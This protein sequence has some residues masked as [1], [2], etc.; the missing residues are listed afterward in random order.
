[1]Y[2]EIIRLLH[3]EKLY[4]AGPECFYTNGYTLWDSMKKK[5]E[6]Y[7]F[8]VTMP[9]DNPVDLTHEDLRE[10]AKAIFENCARCMNESTA[11]LVDLEAFR[12]AEPDG[13][14][15]FELGMAYARGIRCYGYTRDK[16]ATVW[17]HQ[18]VSLRDGVVCGIDGKQLPYQDIPFAP[19]IFGSS[20]IIEGSLD[21]CLGLLMIDIEQENKV[22]RSTPKSAETEIPEKHDR[23]VVYLASTVRYD[24]DAGKKLQEMKQLCQEY[25]YDVLTPLD[26]AAGEEMGENPYQLAAQ[27]FYRFQKHVRSCDIILADLNDFRG[28]EPSC[29]V[30]F[31][32]GM[33]YQLGKKLFGYMRDTS[34]MRERIPNYGRDREYRDECGRNAEDFDY[35]INLMFAGS[36]PI[37][38]ADC[39]KQAVDEMHRVLKSQAK[40]GIAL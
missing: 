35:P 2:D 31:E 15:I 1:M 11:I 19:S 22:M 37:I 40:E 27:Q 23:P 24:P 34:K 9:S 5:A 10:N 16:R 38:K 39:F 36:M 3:K 28:H 7:G 20:K 12:G 17:K 29:D 32:C 18:G 25:G 13:G 14:S 8:Q 4:L 30:S 6:Y 26:R 21:D 33:G